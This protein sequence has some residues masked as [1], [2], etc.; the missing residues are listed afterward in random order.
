MKTRNDY[1]IVIRPL[2]VEDGGGYLAEVSDLPGC[3]ADGD[4]VDEA[5]HDVESAVQSWMLTA[6]EFGD[7]DSIFKRNICSICKHIA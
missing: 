2:F 4:T 1:P 3:M 6:T 7:L 5:L